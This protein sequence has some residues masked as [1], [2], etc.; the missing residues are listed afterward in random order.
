MKAGIR[1]DNFYNSS[2]AQLGLFDKLK[3]KANSEALM[4]IMGRLNKAGRGTLWFV[5]QGIEKPWQMKREKLSLPYMTRFV[6]V[7]KVR[8]KLRFY[9]LHFFISV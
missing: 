8:L 7:L 2:V 9:L 4:R 6:D 1:L 5:G 3:P